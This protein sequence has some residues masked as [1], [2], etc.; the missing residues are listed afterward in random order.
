MKKLLH[1][2]AGLFLV[3]LPLVCGGFL[4]YCNGFNTPLR[5][6][7]VLFLQDSPITGIV[8]GLTLLLIGLIY[9]G[10]FGRSRP[11]KETSL[12]FGTE[13]GIVS[14]GVETVV[15]FIR[16]VGDEFGA[17][18]F[19][20]PRISSKRKMITIILDIKV[21]AGTRIP[22]LSQMIQNRV[23]ESISDGLGIVEIRGIKV[24]VCEIVGAPLPS[25][26][27]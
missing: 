5:D 3:F 21:Q 7:L 2:L 8:A 9:L 20:H 1:G 19:M 4:V 15:E 13:D 17:V 18:L 25:L 10:T 12:S 23:R 6:R 27:E 26:A 22:E 24:H 11:P 14:I 16:K